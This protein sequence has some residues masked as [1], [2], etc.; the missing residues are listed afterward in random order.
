MRCGSVFMGTPE[1]AVPVLDALVAAGHDVVA[2]YSQP[3]RP[4]EP[5]QGRAFTGAGAR[6]G[7]GDRGADARSPCAI[8]RRRR[9]VRRARRGC[10]GG[11]RLWADPAAEPCSM[12]RGWDASTS[13]ARCCRAGAGRRRSSGRSL[14]AMPRRASGS[15]RW[16]P[17]SIRGR[18]GSRGGRRSD[19]K[20]AGDLDRRTERDGRAADG[21]GVGRCG[22][23]I[24]PMP[25]PE[26][27][28]TYAS[29]DR[30]GRGAARL[31]RSRPWRSSGRCAR[32]TRRRGRSSRCMASACGC[33]RPT[34]SAERGDDRRPS[35]TIRLTIACGEGAIRPTLVQRAGRGVM[36]SEE[37]LRG[38]PD[39]RGHA[40]LTRFAL[41]VEYD[42]RP[43]MGW[44][45]QDHGPSV[46]AGD[47]GR[48]VRDH[49]RDGRGA[50]R[51]AHR[52]RRPRAGHAR[53]SRYRTRRS[54]RSG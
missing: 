34:V 28:V 6:R 41:T 24:R 26:D 20:T 13:M 7:A 48:G 4:R 45:R 29:E 31:L 27:G 47:R 50:R 5:G 1:F 23:H 43:F 39:P 11:G 3:P 32:S 42:G 33:M 25:Q 40:A 21:R 9:D 2:A 53:A 18:C 49:R 10:R 35:S 44:Q 52:C 16:R 46:Q 17:G 38:F 14:R 19:G 8:R 51:R 54:R 37:L 30:Q 15:C 12:R 22:S 36:T